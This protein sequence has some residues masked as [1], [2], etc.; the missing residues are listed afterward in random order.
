VKKDQSVIDLAW[1]ILQQPDTVLLLSLICLVA[2]NE[3][4]RWPDPANSNVN[5]EGWIS[6]EGRCGEK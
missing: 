2:G 4:I 6:P 3:E 5:E 1:K